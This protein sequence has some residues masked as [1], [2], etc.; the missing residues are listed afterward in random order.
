MT[1]VAVA[2]AS[3]LLAC[4]GPGLDPNVEPVTEGEWV[5]PDRS[6]TWQWQLDGTID[7]AYDVQLYDVDLFETPQATIDA[8]HEQGRTVICYFSAGS[9]ETYRP[10]Y[11][12]FTGRDKGWKLDGWA[13]ERWLDVR[14]PNVL[15][16]M[17][18]RLDLAV[19]KRCDG[20]EPDNMDGFLN[21][22]GFRLS[23]DNQLGYNRRLANEAH[24][25][26]LA[27][28]LKNE[29]DQARE[30]VDYYDFSLNEECHHYDECGQLQPFLDADK[31]ILNVEY[32]GS[33]A[34]ALA[35]EDELCARAQA[36]GTTTLLMPLELDD[37]FRV[38][39]DG[40]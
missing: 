15:A 12:R 37:R 5:R 6:T 1:R 11:D 25:R 27:I 2:L 16:I 14:S 38:A 33:E 10:D 23:A 17:L 8:L 21:R 35:R 32:P 36:A 22:T 19:D 39:C 34:K 4:G 7:T 9:S 30:L 18:D 40:D 24:E 20:V 3:L 28:A 29:G 26:G 31:P 13:G